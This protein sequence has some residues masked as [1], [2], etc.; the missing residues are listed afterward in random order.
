MK[1]TAHNFIYEDKEISLVEEGDALFF[2]IISEA[3]GT[4]FYLGNN[5]KE[6]Y[7]SIIDEYPD[8]DYKKHTIR[9]YKNSILNADVSEDDLYNLNKEGSRY[10]SYIII[11]AN[12]VIF[13]I[14]ID[15]KNKNSFIF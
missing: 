15:N 8:F 6:F 3:N 7:L 11:Y 10:E 2:D 4:Y 14:L 9:C 13:R 12:K 1:S 5:I